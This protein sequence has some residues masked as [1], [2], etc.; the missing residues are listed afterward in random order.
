M[1]GVDVLAE[2][3]DFAHACIHQRFRFVNDTH[4]GSMPQS[5]SA[6]DVDP[7]DPC[8]VS[9]IHASWP[10]GCDSGY[11][12]PPADPKCQLG[13]THPNTEDRLNLRCFDQ[14]RRFGLDFLY[15]VSRYIN[16]LA[17]HEVPR[18]DGTMAPNP[19]YASSSAYPDLAPRVGSSRVFFAG[20]VGVP[21]QDIA[22]DA[23]L[24]A[25]QLLEFLRLL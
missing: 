6:C 23:T 2:Q 8:C 18:R 16:G 21:W 15:P 4:E 22:T 14:K 9:C 24:N 11:D 20:I 19:L 1:I 3:R 13:L 17:A 10:D 7:N 25:P 5:T 12:Q